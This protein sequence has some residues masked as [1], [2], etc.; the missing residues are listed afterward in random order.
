MEFACIGF[1][2]LLLLTV[3]YSGLK[4]AKHK[5]TLF[6]A[7]QSALEQLKTEPNNANL[8]QQTLSLGREYS[9]LTR[10]HKGV[11]VFD[12][13][14]IKNDIDAACASTVRVQ[15]VT[16]EQKLMQ[17]QQIYTSGHITSDEYQTKKQEILREL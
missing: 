16:I 5:A 11:T 7:Y 8:R 2:A 6:Q 10:D 12:E 15:T 14:A 3:V 9:N 4:A 13:I 17:L 1:G